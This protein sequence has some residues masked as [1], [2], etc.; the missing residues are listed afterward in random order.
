MQNLRPLVA[1]IL[2]LATSGIANADGHDIFKSDCAIC[3]QASAKGVPGTFPPLADSIG[4]Y[5][6]IPEGRAYLVHVV[7]FGLTGAISVH[8]HT[9]NGV[10]QPWPNLKNQDIALLLNYVLTTFNAKLLPNDFSPLTGDEV[11]KYRTSSIV[12]GD[13]HKE[14]EALMKALPAH[15]GGGS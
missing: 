15:P 2:L 12:P 10:M 4:S 5:V 14:R 13:V 7:A 6:A 3:H 8:G 9:Y 11:K 1:L